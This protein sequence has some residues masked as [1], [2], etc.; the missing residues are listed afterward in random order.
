MD[1]RR[2][3]AFLAVVDEGSVTAAAA[4]LHVAQPSLSQTLR[5]LEREL[6]VELFVR[7]GRGLRLT[8]AGHEL[9]GP[10][11]E[12][13]R[14]LQSARE[15]VAEVAGLQTGSLELSAL[16]TLAVDPLAGLVGAFRRAH[17][18]VLVRVREPDSALGVTEDVRIGAAELGLAN[19]PLRTGELVSRPL[20]EQE[21]LV[22]LPPNSEGADEPISAAA[23]AQLPL[24]VSPPGTSTRMLLE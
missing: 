3:G 24:V 11:R 19:V 16:A 20:G 7:A 1:E 4:R 22:V 10:A 5:S 13:L 9:V 21:L 15:T 23:L 2:L 12:A 17:P 8:A 14:A 18:G 6:A